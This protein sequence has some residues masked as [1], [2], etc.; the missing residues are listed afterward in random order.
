[1]GTVRVHDLTELI[2]AR[3]Q[4]QQAILEDDQSLSTDDFTRIAIWAE[5][6]ALWEVVE[7]IADVLDG[8]ETD[9]VTIPDYFTEMRAA[10]A[11]KKLSRG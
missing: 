2:K 3:L 9:R 7:A 6:D 5:I 11:R 8:I 4:D 1:M 10:H